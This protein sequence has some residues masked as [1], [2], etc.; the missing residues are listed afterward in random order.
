VSRN[1]LSVKKINSR[2][3]K[4]A[5]FLSPLL[6]EADTIRRK[7][8]KGM[9]H[10][11]VRTWYD[12]VS[13]WLNNTN[14]IFCDCGWADI[15]ADAE[16]LILH[17]EDEIDRK[18]INLYHHVTSAVNLKDLDVLEVGCG[19]GG[20]ASY[21]M[22]YLKPRTMI[23][24]DISLKTIDFCKHYYNI[25]GLTFF[26]GKAEKLAF[27]SESFDAVINI[28]SSLSY[29]SMDKFL[30]QVYR[31]LKKR[32]HF[33]YADMREKRKYAALHRQIK[34]SGLKIIREIDISAN[35][36]KSIE[37]EEE[38]KKK[39]LDKGVPAMIRPFFDIFFAAKNTEFVYNRLHS[40]E[41]KYFSLVLQK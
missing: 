13:H 37:Q 9:Q 30:E 17:P 21:V 25:P 38:R 32:G 14:I 8:P 36:V 33:L 34:Q 20:G 28:E 35:V 2:L 18:G 5:A 10:A 12:L 22:R 24:I 15:G 11:I 6:L 31:I 7:L 29:P 39:A 1:T 19:R 23:A 26:H 41:R 40:G 16:T 4:S 27:D 3:K